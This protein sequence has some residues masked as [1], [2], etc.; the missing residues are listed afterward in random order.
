MKNLA[1]TVFVVSLL[2]VLVLYLISFQVRET[3]S[4]L[5]TTFGKPTRAIVKPG[6]YF[7]WPF[8]IQLVHKFDSRM[9]VFEVT[10]DET[11]T[12][13]AVPIIVNTYVVWR[14]AEPL[15]FY[16][17]VG[18]I[19]EA[20]NKLRSQI[21]DTQN[22]VV[23]R[24]FFSEFVNSDPAK[25]QFEQIEQEMRA[26]LSRAVQ[27]EYGIKIEMLGMK[28]L[29]VSEAVSKDVFE[30]MRAERNRR[31][32]ETIAQGQAQAT[33]LTADAERKRT[34]ILAAAR[35]R[36]RTIRGQGDAEAAKY[37]ELLQADP[38][39]AMF[40]RETEALRKILKERATYVAPADAAPFRLLREMPTIK[41]AEAD[42]AKK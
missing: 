41:P 3:E 6:W 27:D 1:I 29:K 32:E 15:K 24:R 13:G 26:D 28:Q 33:K 21:K 37:Y 23:G 17:A 14:I 42:E 7:R 31:T 35:A 8:P 16:N 10:P 38:E 11:T 39:L 4:A 25:V 36:A 20:Q 30:R 18:T 40:L 9:R 5:V 34:E 19:T 2:A 22:R 12:K